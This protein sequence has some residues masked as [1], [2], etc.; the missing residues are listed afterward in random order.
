[1]LERL[2]LHRD[3]KFVVAVQ[4]KDEG[5]ARDGVKKLFACDGS[6]Y[7]IGFLD[8]YAILGE[9]QKDVD[10]SIAATKKESLGDS[11]DF[12][13]D[14]DALD[15]GIA[16]AWFDGKAILEVPELKQE[17]ESSGQD[18]GDLDKVGSFALS[19]RVD[20]D[21]IEL[22][23]LGEADDSAFGKSSET[24]L[25]TLPTGTIAA[26]SI[27]GYGD[28]IADQFDTF[29]QQFDSTVGA[30]A[31][32]DQDLA[33]MGLTR[34]EYEQYVGETPDAQSYIDQ[35]EQATG[36]N[37]KEDLQTLFGDALTL[38]IGGDNLEKFAT[39]SS[40]DDIASL[41]AALS[42]TSDP[43]KALDLIKRLAALAAQAGIPLTTSANDKGAVLAT[44][45]EFGDAV[46]DRK[47]K[48]GDDDAFSSVIP[49]GSDL[50][51]LYVNLGAIVDKLQKADPPQE[52]ADVLDQLKPLSAFG[53]SGEK[54][55]DDRL[56]F[57]VRL[58]FR[59]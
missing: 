33:D 48:L 5:E 56:K 57:S 30:A 10:A 49:D 21:A 29:V 9:S 4:V 14:F 53:A 52:I 27:P 15:E 37:A 22:S 59:D 43:T 28:L 54:L 38:A 46:A 41:D 19:L 23:A 36:L 26:L 20:G 51:G 2:D 17:L 44:N 39:F 31:P 8:G 45:Q 58:S 35:F 55:G 16:S 42:L 40:P 12:T 13:E 32:T 50:G 34:E 18:F 47:G 11:E 1:M 7:G 24:D 3:E 6:S 25:A